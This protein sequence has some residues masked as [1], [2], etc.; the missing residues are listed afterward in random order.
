MAR[1]MQLPSINSGKSPHHFW[2]VF[3]SLMQDNHK[4]HSANIRIRG[5]TCK[6]LIVL[7]KCQTLLLYYATY[8]PGMFIFPSPVCQGEIL[9]PSQGLKCLCHNS[10]AAPHIERNLDLFSLF[11]RIMVVMTDNDQFMPRP[12]RAFMSNLQ[13]SLQPYHLHILFKVC[14]DWQGRLSASLPVSLPFSP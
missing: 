8:Y 12:R 1:H 13:L 7:F 14:R 11:L 6:V 10:G 4:S 3:S 5:G 9:R 2:L